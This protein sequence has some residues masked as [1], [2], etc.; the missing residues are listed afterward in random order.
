MLLLAVGIGADGELE[1]AAAQFAL[2]G[3]ARVETAVVAVQVDHAAGI[4]RVA[5][6]AHRDRE[7]LGDVA[8]PGVAH[9]PPGLLVHLLG[10][11]RAGLHLAGGLA[12]VE[13]AGGGSG[14]ARVGGDLGAAQAQRILRIGR[15]QRVEQQVQAPPGRQVDADLGVEGGALG[16]AVV[17]VAVGAEMGGRQ[18]VVDVPLL[19]QRL[20]AEGSGAVAADRTAQPPRIVRLAV[21]APQLHHA[22]GRVAVQRRE[23]PAQHLDALAAEQVEVGQLALAIRHRRRDAV[24]QQANAAYAE[25]RA[26][27]EAADRQLG[28]LRIVLAIAREQ[29]GH[30]DQ[31]LG[32][33][34]AEAVAVAQAGRGQRRRQVEIGHAADAGGLDLEHWQGGGRILAGSGVDQGR[35]RQGAGPAKQG[36]GQGR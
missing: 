17:A 21:G 7:V 34:Y 3:P 12:G 11:D 5:L 29:A 4:E 23:R 28:V 15:L 18:V 13:L 24:Q 36:G 31:R 33:L 6:R 25:R 30:P 9:Q 16:A 14:L 27:A 32:R 22:A 20:R 2:P 8:A 26:R 1:R 19:A 10:E 35:Q